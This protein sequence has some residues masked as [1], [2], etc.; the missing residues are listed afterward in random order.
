MAES[1]VVNVTESLLQ[2][3]SGDDS[4]FQNNKLITNL[5]S[6][7]IEEFLGQKNIPGEWWALLIGWE[8]RQQWSLCGTYIIVALFNVMLSTVTQ[9]FIGHQL[10]AME[11]AGAS[12]AILEIQNLGFIVMS[13]MAIAV[14]TLC[15]EASGAKK[16]DS[17]GIICQ[18]AII[19]Q[20][21][22]AVVLSAFY[23]Y[24]G[25]ILETLGLWSEIG[26]KSQIFALGLIPQLYAYALS[27]PMQRFLQ[28]QNIM[29]PLAYIAVTVFL[30]HFVLTWVVVVAFNYGLMGAALTL[31]FSWW[32]L[33]LITGVYILVSPSCQKTWT[34]F[35]TNAFSG[36]WVYSKL[37]LASIFMLSFETWFSVGLMLSAA[38]FADPTVSV[39]S[40]AICI[41]YLNCDFTIMLGLSTAAIVR[42]GTEI[43]SAHPRVARLSAMVVSGTSILISI[44]CSALVLACGPALSKVFIDDVE[45]LKTV[46]DFVP[47]LAISIFLNGV[48]PILSGVVIGF[49][50]PGLVVLLYACNYYLVGFTFGYSLA[51]MTDF[52]V[53]GIWW[54]VILGFSVQALVLLIL[55]IKTNLDKVVDN[56]FDC[57]RRSGK[58]ELLHDEPSV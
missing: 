30:L 1:T 4:D 55:V 7:S 52:G 39:A 36:L 53:A 50:R 3:Q 37:A 40:F 23:W 24:S 49:G 11:F 5:N 19:V 18:K 54:G 57:S 10:G 44:I 15:R 48:E 28:A 29:N 42:A 6:D 27:F 34:G 12:M 16:L 47:L 17:L 32:L 25:T 21:A 33:V 13:G 8:I 2:Y 35:S 45:V 41:N 38:Y 43:E 14:Q 31:S 22:A 26:D 56:G 20:L 46:S 58:E 9:M 51:F